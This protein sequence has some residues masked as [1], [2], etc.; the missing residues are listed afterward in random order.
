MAERGNQTQVLRRDNFMQDPSKQDGREEPQEDKAITSQGSALAQAPVADVA[1][2][3]ELSNEAGV[4][5]DIYNPEDRA[6]DPEDSKAA[7]F[8]A[9]KLKG[10][11]QTAHERDHQER[12]LDNQGSQ[13][14]RSRT[15]RQSQRRETFGVDGV[16]T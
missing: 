10:L 1:A 12:G 16:L 9:Q 3:G 14:Q 6:R 11:T 4:R 8:K 7:R 15:P 2:N 13:E 5:V